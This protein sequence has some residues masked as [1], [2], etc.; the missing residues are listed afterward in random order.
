MIGQA[1][2]RG[3]GRGVHLPVEIEGAAEITFGEVY[4]EEKPGREAAGKLVQI[5]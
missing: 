1:D 4:G 5:G 3:A 2:D